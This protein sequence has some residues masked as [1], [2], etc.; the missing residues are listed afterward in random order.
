MGDANC[1]PLLFLAMNT[2][3]SPFYRSEEER[4]ILL[5]KAMLEED[6]PLDSDQENHAKESAKDEGEE[7]ENGNYRVDANTPW[8]V[9]IQHAMRYTG[10]VTVQDNQISIGDSKGA[11]Q[12]AIVGLEKCLSAL[13]REM[14]EENVSGLSTVV[15]RQ[16]SN[17]RTARRSLVSTLRFLRGLD[18]DELL[19]NEEEMQSQAALLAQVTTI[20]RQQASDTMSQT[21]FGAPNIDD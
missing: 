20:A 14:E 4:R 7:A 6:E 10:P 19:E 21:S 13:A 5:R 12:L 8:T 1:A 2:I 3:R 11:S 9:L 16:L 18:A 15:L 17:N